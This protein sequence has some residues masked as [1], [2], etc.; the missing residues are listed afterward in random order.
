M[1]HSSQSSQFLV[2][3]VGKIGYKKKLIWHKLLVYCVKEKRWGF[4]KLLISVVQYNTLCIIKVFKSKCK[5]YLKILNLDWFEI[6]WQSEKIE[7][8]SQWTSG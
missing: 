3:G 4:F 2:D 1:H 5:R 7:D 6:D 8:R